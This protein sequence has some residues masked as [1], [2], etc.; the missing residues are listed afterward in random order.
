MIKPV[1]S[2]FD[3]EK[4]RWEFVLTDDD[5]QKVQQSYACGECLEDFQGEFK[6]KCPVCK[7]S[8]AGGDRII[9]DPRVS[10]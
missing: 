7:H 8:T 3:H 6:L 5:F 10:F 9:F 4:N 2:R 1:Y